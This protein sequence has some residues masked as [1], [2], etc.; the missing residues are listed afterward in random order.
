MA[1][2]REEAARAAAEA[3]DQVRSLQREVSEYKREL[4]QKASA[5]ARAVEEAREAAYS[6]AERLRGEQEATSFTVSDST[7]EIHNRSV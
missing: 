4:E 7:S 3:A 1:L 5:E 6:D 2:V